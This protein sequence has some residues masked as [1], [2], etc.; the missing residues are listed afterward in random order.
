[1]LLDVSEPILSDPTNEV[2]THAR[3][4]I[5]RLL[6]PSMFV[7]PLPLRGAENGHPQSAPAE[8]P[9]INS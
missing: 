3:E 2:N 9:Q 1:M 5:T 4:W 7:S 8:R 6:L